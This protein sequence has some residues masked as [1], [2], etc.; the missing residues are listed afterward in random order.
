M[1]VVKTVMW[2]TDHRQAGHRLAGVTH[3]GTSSTTAL[4]R[5][6]TRDLRS[7]SFCLTL[8]ITQHWLSSGLDWMGRVAQQVMPPNMLWPCQAALIDICDT[9]SN[10]LAIVSHML[11]CN[12]LCVWLLQK[13]GF[14]DGRARV[15]VA[16]HEFSPE[17]PGLTCWR[18]ILSAVWCQ[19]VEILPTATLIQIDQTTN[20]ASQHHKMSTSSTQS[21]WSVNIS[22][23]RVSSINAHIHLDAHLSSRAQK[24]R[25]GCLPHVVSQRCVTPHASKIR[26]W[27]HNN[28]RRAN[29]SKHPHTPA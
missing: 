1:L 3:P 28:G 10:S 21:D 16:P 23:S 25:V 29:W 5:W 4:A 2:V 24:T 18:C 27:P 13:C 26:L 12:C 8:V 14:G 20:S 22:Y 11:C 6:T 19:P 17:H 7:L 9:R 15:K